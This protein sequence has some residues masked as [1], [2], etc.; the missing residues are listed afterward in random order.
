MSYLMFITCALLEQ[1]NDDDVD[2]D[3][4]DDDDDDATLI[5]SWSSLRRLGRRSSEVE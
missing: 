1:I 2:D 4:D 3:D 5:M